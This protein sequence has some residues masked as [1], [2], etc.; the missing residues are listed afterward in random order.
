MK[1]FV[2]E[3][4]RATGSPAYFIGPSVDIKYNKHLFTPVLE[5]AKMYDSMGH[6]VA[7]SEKLAAKV[8]IIFQHRVIEIELTATL[9][10]GVV[11]RKDFGQKTGDQSCYCVDRPK[12]VVTKD[13][14]TV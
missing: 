14:E 8:P 10:G 6:A 2:I 12:P 11:R 1:K 7:T 9:T 13:L 3:V 5:D 4:T